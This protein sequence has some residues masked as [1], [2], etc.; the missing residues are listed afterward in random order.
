M[1]DAPK[2][3]WEL[4]GTARNFAG[5]GSALAVPVAPSPQRGGASEPA[6][7]GTATSNPYGMT[8]VELLDALGPS[9]NEIATHRRDFHPC[10]RSA[11]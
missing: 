2:S 11:A 9:W 1:T 8:D 10:Y 6:T 3:L 4:T 5:T 7:P